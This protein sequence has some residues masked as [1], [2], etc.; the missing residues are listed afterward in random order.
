MKPGN[1][2][3]ILM[4]FMMYSIDSK[5]C[6]VFCLYDINNKIVGKSNGWGL[7][8]GYIIINQRKVLKKGFILGRDKPIKWISKYGSLTFNQISQEMPNGGINE[9]GLIIEILSSAAEYPKKDKRKAINESQWIQY[10]LDNFE[11]V[12]QVIESEAY[13]RVRRAASNMHYFISDKFG[14]YASIDFFEGK[15]EVH[16]NEEMPIPVLTNQPYERLIGSANSGYDLQTIK[17]DSKRRFLIAHEIIKNNQKPFTDKAW[18][19]IKGCKQYINNYNVVYDLNNMTLSFNDP[20][21]NEIKIIYINELNFDCGL[22]KSISFNYQT[23]GKVN[24]FF[25]PYSKEINKQ[26]LEKVFKQLVDEGR[27]KGLK[28]LLTRLLYINKLTKII[29]KQT[30]GIG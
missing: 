15:F 6:T 11:N 24:E 21:N 3:I 16:L 20:I 28:K 17:D 14:N 2:F 9:R 8:E 27:I 22:T 26:Q 29:K 18:D 19:I 7:K 23:G 13:I 12:N 10:Q 4:I 30:C 25:I 5:A 1:I